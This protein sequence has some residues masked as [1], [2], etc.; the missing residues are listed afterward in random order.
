MWRASGMIPTAS[1]AVASTFDQCTTNVGGSVARELAQ[2]AGAGRSHQAPEPFDVGWFKL[3]G[4]GQRFR[5][6][7][8]WGGRV[9]GRG[10]TRRRASRRRARRGEQGQG[11][12]GNREA[13]IT[14]HSV[15][16]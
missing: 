8:L 10:S 12:H 13:S 7:G 5:R 3:L 16:L 6:A 2:G 15:L 1:G 14:R 4:D 11:G 9:V